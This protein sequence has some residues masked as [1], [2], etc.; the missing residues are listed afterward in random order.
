MVAYEDVCR[1]E[2]PDWVVVVG[3]VNSTMAAAI[4][5]KKLLLPG[6]TS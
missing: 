2:R 1:I 5:A 3:D 6:R 4:V